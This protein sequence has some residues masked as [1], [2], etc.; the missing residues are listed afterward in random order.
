MRTPPRPRAGE[1]LAA[2]AATAA[3]LLGVVAV[4]AA[5][6][7]NRPVTAAALACAAALALVVLG[8]WVYRHW[9]GYRTHQEHPAPL[10]AVDDSW[11]TEETLADF[12]AEAV[13]PLL[14]RSG[15]PGPSALYTA[16]VLAVHGRDAAWLD[17]HLDL[18]PGVARLLTDRAR[19]RP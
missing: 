8:A 4:K 18:P 1:G 9:A 12:P 7:S 10:G 16:W 14:P 3:G 6:D 13:R 15:A 19:Q 17:R 2:V 5:A 11:F